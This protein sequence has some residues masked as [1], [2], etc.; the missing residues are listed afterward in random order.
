MARAW[1]HFN[2]NQLANQTFNINN[3]HIICQRYRGVWGSL[4]ALPVTQQ[5]IQAMELATTG[6]SVTFPA[7]YTIGTEGRS[8]YTTPQDNRHYYALGPGVNDGWGTMAAQGQAWIGR[9]TIVPPNDGRS[10]VGSGNIAAVKYGGAT[11][12][13]DITF[14]APMPDAKYA[15][16][17]SCS[18]DTNGGGT[19]VVRIVSPT[20]SGFRITCST[21]SGANLA[22]GWVSVVAFR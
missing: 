16:V 3:Q 6:W 12:V 9:I 1:L 22:P 2:G 19:G 10:I 20:V 5:K 13:F 21:V 7:N 4:A 15:V 17:A 8:N 14:Q 11:G 18:S